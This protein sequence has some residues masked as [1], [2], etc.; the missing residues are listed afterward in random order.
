LLYLKFCHR[1][2]FI[3]TPAYPEH[4]FVFEEME[5]LKKQPLEKR[6]SP[7]DVSDCVLFLASSKAIF[8]TG[9]TVKV[10]G[11]ITDA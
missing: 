2:G 5:E 6:G 9:T 3:K 8:I 11:G 4:G 7:T 1:P 10:D